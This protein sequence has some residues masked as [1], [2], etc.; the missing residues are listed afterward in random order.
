ME[1]RVLPIRFRTGSP[2]EPQ[3]PFYQVVRLLRPGL[4]RNLA[5]E[6]ADR[7]RLAA[8]FRFSSP[9]SAHHPGTPRFWLE[10]AEG[11]SKLAAFLTGRATLK[12]LERVTGRRCTPCRSGGTYVY[13]RQQ[14]QCFGLHRDA[15]HCQLALI[16]CVYDKPGKGGDLVLY[17]GRGGESLKSILA[18]PRRGARRIRLRAGESLLLDGRRI[19][20]RVTPIGRGRLRVTATACY[21]ASPGRPES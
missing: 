7:S 5:I 11:G 3:P 4:L 17:P 15:P 1:W 8:P 13:Y 19:A 9:S 2:I 12:R 6:A 10:T 14:T 20:H 18:S 21:R 16:T